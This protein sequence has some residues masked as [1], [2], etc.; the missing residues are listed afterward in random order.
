MLRGMAQILRLVL[1]AI[2]LLITVPFAAMFAEPFYSAVLTNFGI[3][4]SRWAGPAVSWMA[5]AAANPVFHAVAIFIVGMTTGAWA[6]WVA[7]RYDR[8]A[9][10]RHDGKEDLIR[11]ADSIPQNERN[12]VPP[13]IT[14]ERLL[15]FYLDKTSIQADNITR[16]YIDQWITVSGFVIEVWPYSN[17][18]SAVISRSISSTHLLGLK[19]TDTLMIFRNSPSISRLKGLKESDKISVVGQIMRITRSD[20]TL[21]NC[22]IIDPDLSDQSLIS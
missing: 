8:R 1:A 20:L 10:A 4:T 22:E 3:D 7:T 11:I 9:V 14:Q 16:D 18:Y 21:D 6:H 13:E 5:A 12:F 17:G 15:G 2:G 19:S